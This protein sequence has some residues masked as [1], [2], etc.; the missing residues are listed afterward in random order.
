MFASVPLGWTGHQEE[1]AE[2]DV[3]FRF[4]KIGQ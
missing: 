1:E 3:N 4:L 2:E